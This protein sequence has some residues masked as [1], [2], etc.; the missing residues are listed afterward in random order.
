MSSIDACWQQ[1][2]WV[3]RWL[4]LAQKP[5]GTP[6]LEEGW[7]GSWKWSPGKEADILA[8]GDSFLLQLGFLGSALPALSTRTHSPSSLAILL[9]ASAWSAPHTKGSPPASSQGLSRN[10][11][12]SPS[13]SGERV[14]SICGNPCRITTRP[15]PCRVQKVYLHSLISSLLLLSIC[16]VPGIVLLLPVSSSDGEPTTSRGSPTSPAQKT[17]H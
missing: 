17:H 2:F 12:S 15:A 7:G 6:A 11:I 9:P 16:H 4:W 13:R 5:P 14:H 8:V 10:K 3:C 1:I